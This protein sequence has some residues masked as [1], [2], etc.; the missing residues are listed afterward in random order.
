MIPMSTL[1]VL[2]LCQFHH[3]ELVVKAG[4]IMLQGPQPARDLVRDLVR[5]HKLEL[6]AVLAAPP[7]PQTAPLP[8]DAQ[9]Q[10]W[11]RDYLGRPANLWG[12]RKPQ[13]GPQ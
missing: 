1:S 8:P 4:K 9:G 13:G 7:A 3:V 5:D 11:H 10:E 2:R 12:L 6:M